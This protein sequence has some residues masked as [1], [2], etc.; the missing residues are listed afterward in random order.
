MKRT[1]GLFL[2]EQLADLPKPDSYA[3]S[4]EGKIVIITG[5]N[6]GLGFEAAK[7][8]AR[9]RPGR[10][11]LACRDPKKAQ[12][13]LQDIKTATGCKSVDAWQLDISSNE[14]VKAFADRFAKEGGTKVDI[15]IG[16]AGVNVP[17]MERTPDGWEKNIGTN[18]IGT[19]H[20]ALRMLPFLLQAP[21]PRLVILASDVHYFTYKSELM[22]RPDLL[23]SLNADK[24][25]NRFEGFANIQRY[26]LSKTMNVFFGHALAERIPSS[27]PLTV[28]TV[29][30]GFCVSAL[31]RDHGVM[32]H[33]FNR[34][35]GRS[36]EVGSRTLV[37]AAV[38]PDM[39]GKTGVYLSS[40]VVTEPSDFVISKQ[41]QEAE[42]K[43]WDETMDIL[44]KVDP[45]VSHIAVTYLR[46]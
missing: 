21:Q 16:N 2:R 31:L 11:I 10:L 38:A 29:N 39:Q 25:T 5:S 17:R 33:I 7:H 24:P 40:C 18:H 8:L 43:L 12:I 19:A 30:P 9:M 36:T 37:H 34:L 45:E 44:G 3:V 26:E 20:F 46:H 6:I 28:S 4:L 23:H 35:I 15:L 22:N 13:A 1:V 41:G 14:S 32:R 27:S 42:E